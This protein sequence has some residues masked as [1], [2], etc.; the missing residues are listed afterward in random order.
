MLGERAAL[1]KK[2][3]ELI[4]SINQ[5][6]NISSKEDKLKTI[7]DISDKYNFPINLISDLFS[8]RK[9]LSEVDNFT[10][11]AIT[12]VINNSKIGYYFTKK[13]IEVY[14][15]SKYYIGESISDITFNMIQVDVDQ[16]I[17]VTDAKTLMEL[18]KQQKIYYNGDTQRALQHVVRFGN[19]IL[20]PYLNKNAVNSI[21]EKYRNGSFIPNTITL[22]LP[23]E[24]EYSYDEKKHQ[25]TVYDLDH[26]D[27]TDGYHRYV[28]M[29]N[30]YDSTENFNYPV[31]L[32]ITK[33]PTA[34]AQDF[35]YQEDHKTKMRRVE[36]KYM[37]TTDYGNMIVRRLDGDSNLAG[38]INNRNGIV[39]APYLADF[40][41]K[42]WKPKSN[43]E[44]VEY[45]KDIRKALNGFTEENTE[46]LEK[47]WSRCE[48]VG[49]FYGI[50]RGL[51]PHF[52]KEFARHISL[53][54]PDI[55]KYSAF[56]K[57]DF[58]I[59]EE[60]VKRYV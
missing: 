9:S 27:I 31:E 24:A 47:K 40:I 16:W 29:G 41:N 28:A 13:E 54:N 18:K 44:V 56:R 37:N 53:K 58:K 5:G 3:Q 55:G 48:I 21:T 42:L 25:L 23:E 22:N 11:F 60:G 32:R 59:L 19:E 12:D 57:Y 50:Y 35:I 36:S 52:T 30:V 17:G 7:K 8:F 51:N 20:Q 1:E 6:N 14:S 39:N 10:L 2:L 26:F 15:Q 4:I 49:V 45:T 38:Q 33:F 43:K 46:Y 34:K